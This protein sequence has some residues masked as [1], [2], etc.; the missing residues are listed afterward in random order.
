MR[1]LASLTLASLTAFA[2]RAGDVEFG[3]KTT[4][5]WLAILK[6]NKEVKLR[7]AAL[8]ALE[9]IG[10]RKGVVEGVREALASDKTPQVRREAALL[11]GRYGVAAKEA[12]GSLG[13]AL[14]ST[15]EEGPVREAAAISLGKLSDFAASQVLVLG[16]ALKDPHVPVVVAAAEALKN[17]KDKGREAFP[18]ILKLAADAKGDGVARRFAIFTVSRFADL[19]G[20]ELE[21]IASALNGVGAESGADTGVR[22]A[23]LDGLGHLKTTLAIPGLSVGLKSKEPELRRTAIRG[24]TLL[25]DKA[26]GAWGAIKPALGD[27]DSIVRNQAIIA[28]GFI[29]KAQAEAVSELT[30]A[31]E[32]DRDLDNRITAIQTLGGLGATAK[33]AM[34]VLEKLAMND[35]R[36]RIREAAKDAARK[37]KG[38]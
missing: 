20:K 34:P 38:S 14:G 26:A 1:W 5:Q 12:V 13:E 15:K 23:A 33:S 29:A 2:A 4:T 11:L 17:L 24:L 9:V 3:G 7:Q 22:E 6:E 35:F 37:I 10:P 32:K 30:G 21:Q 18:D 16:R 8:V 36:A 19:G 27:M 25:K 28:C 31:A